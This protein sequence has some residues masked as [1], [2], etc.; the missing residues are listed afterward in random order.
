MLHVEDI[1]PVEVINVSNHLLFKIRHIKSG[2][3]ENI[4]VSRK[5]SNISEAEIANIST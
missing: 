2:N 3:V 1:S 5:Q 4:L